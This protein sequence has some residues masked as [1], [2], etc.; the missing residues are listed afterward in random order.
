MN[1]AKAIHDLKRGLNISLKIYI[2]TDNEST[3][4]V[5]RSLVVEAEGEISPLTSSIR[6]LG[7][8]LRINRNFSDMG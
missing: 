8:R 5:R 1:I 6:D 2:S 3:N 4:F 7:T